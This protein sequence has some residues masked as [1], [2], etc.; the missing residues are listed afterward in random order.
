M[1]CEQVVERNVHGRGTNVRVPECT[2]D[3]EAFDAVG[4]EESDDGG[5]GDNPDVR[6]AQHEDAGD[7]GLSQRNGAHCG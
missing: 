2:D 4:V 1:I 3:V 6:V 5:G 7:L